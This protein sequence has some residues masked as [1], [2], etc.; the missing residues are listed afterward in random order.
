LRDQEQ[1][2]LHR[3]GISYLT[4][5][6]MFCSAVWQKINL[7]GCLEIQGASGSGKSI[8]LAVGYRLLK[9]LHCTCFIHFAEASGRIRD[10]V[11]NDAAFVVFLGCPRSGYKEITSS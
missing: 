3:S 2:H 5:K 1:I 9:N 11:W 7:P 4:K 6:D 8:C 10:S